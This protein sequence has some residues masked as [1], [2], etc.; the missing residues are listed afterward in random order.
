MKED[1]VFADRREAGRLLSA[2]LGQYAGRNDV[3]VLGLPRGGVPV[4]F[5]VA[6]A[7]GAPLDVYVVRKLGAPFQEELAVGAV[8]SGGATVL[9]SELVAALG[10]EP[11][12]LDAMVARERFEVT[13][14]EQSYRGERQPIDP[15]GRTAI[16]VDDG[17]AT[18]A[19]MRAAVAGLRQL[20]PG[21]IVVA[22]PVAPPEACALLAQEAD[23]VVCLLTPDPFTAVGMWYD[24]FAQTTDDDVRALLAE[25]EQRRDEPATTP[26]GPG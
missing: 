18:G 23:H 8:A 10:I 15:V 6:R 3:L 16:L 13:R 14:R 7:L 12:E 20:G 22:V 4:A 17:L 25:S 19:S 9:N 1:N 2:A 26:A 21:G 5:E 11:E 24:D